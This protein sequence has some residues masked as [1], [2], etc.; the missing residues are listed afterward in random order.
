[1]TV[2][3]K[4]LAWFDSR[5]IDCETVTRCGIYTGRRAPDGEVTPDRS[6]DILVFPF[7][8][9]GKEVG[10]KYRAAGKRF[11]Q[12][13]GGRKT[14]WG[15]GVLEDPAVAA[16]GASLVIVE[17]EIDA[18]SVMQAG[19]PFV[20]SVPDGAPPARDGEG[21]LIQVPK[22]TADI[23]PQ[24]DEKYS[25]IANNWDRLKRVKRITI[26]TDADEPGRRLA[27]ELVRRLDRVRCS[28]V[29]YPEGCKDF[30]DVLVKH[31]AAEITRIIAAAKPYPVSGVY[32]LSEIPPEPELKPVSTGWT[33]LDDYLRV[34]SPALMVVTGFAGQGKTTWTQQLCA[35]L[36]KNEGWVTAIASFEMRI[37]PFVTDSL[38]GVFL[39][40]KPREM[41]TPKD[42]KWSDEWIE[43]HFVFIAPDPEEDR[44]HD[45]SWL[46]ECAEAAVI[47]HGARVLLVDPWNEIDHA[48]RGTESITDYTG[49]AIRDL[50]SFA[51]RYG[52]LVVLVVHPTKSSIHKSPEELSL[53]D[54]SDSAHFANKADL[55]VV[56]AR[57][58]T[59]ENDTT[60]GIFIRK[61]RYQPDMG[62]Q[63]HIDVVFDKATRL[64]SE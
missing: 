26:A 31:G 6:G 17:G 48:R 57:Q 58:G 12:R 7:L 37:R 52:V 11:W 34:C 18:L 53:Y 30:N 19:Y 8:E 62:Q 59:N 23:D 38:A 16:G 13:Q 24:H 50:K 41:W 36:A 4:A 63:G 56:I 51:R 45:I 44:E 28:W 43:K 9:N 54:A 15:S 35:Q 64:F 29:E 21:N 27:E 55:G 20:V 1:M 39:N 33:R 22:G 10:A 47:R 14:F 46:I 2:S 3:E 25:F 32:K 40:R 49:R 60:T 42:R 5:G 61:V